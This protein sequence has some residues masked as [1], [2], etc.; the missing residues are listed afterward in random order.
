MKSQAEIEVAIE[1]LVGKFT[2]TE[3]FMM[4]NGQYDE[5][6]ATASAAVQGALDALLWVMD[7]ESYIDDDIIRPILDRGPRARRAMTADE[8]AM[9]DRAKSTSMNGSQADA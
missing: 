5:V 9:L 1:A 3:E 7:R 8:Q 2:T 4:A 6:S